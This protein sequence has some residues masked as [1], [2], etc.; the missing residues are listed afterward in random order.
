MVG[1]KE[2]KTLRLS[3]LPADPTTTAIFLTNSPLKFR[4]IYSID[5][6][7]S[8]MLN[9]EIQLPINERKINI[10]NIIISHKYGSTLF[11]LSFFGIIMGVKIFSLNLLLSC[12]LM[13]MGFSLFMSLFGF[14]FMSVKEGD[15]YKLFIASLLVLF[16]GLYELLPKLLS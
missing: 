15:S 5:L 11:L 7:K 3:A 9:Q 2:L 10:K 4:K 12:I 13:A 1:Y 14:Y 8:L 16:F 6:W